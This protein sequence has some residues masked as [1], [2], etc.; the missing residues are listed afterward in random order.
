MRKKKNNKI[1]EHHLSHTHDINSTYTYNLCCTLQNHPVAI[2][3][4]SALLSHPLRSLTIFHF[5]HFFFPRSPSTFLSVTRLRSLTASERHCS[6][7]REKGRCTVDLSDYCSEMQI[8]VRRFLS[9]SLSSSLSLTSAAEQEP[10]DDRI[11]FSDTLYSTEAPR[12]Y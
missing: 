3:F 7:E 2:S 4:F 11:L 6:P 10:L 8:R 12:A 1:K 9:V 5:F